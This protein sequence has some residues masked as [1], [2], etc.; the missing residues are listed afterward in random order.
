MRTK[1]VVEL[2]IKD[3]GAC[4][5]R[6]RSLDLTSRSS[7][8]LWRDYL[9]D[10]VREW[11]K[12]SQSE[13]DPFNQYVSIFTAYNTLYDLYGAM[14]HPGED[15]SRH[16]SQLAVEAAELISD[17]NSLIQ[18]LQPKLADY[19]RSIPVFREEYYKENNRVI[20]ISE[21]LRESLGSGHG[22][23]TLQLL[24]RWFYKVRCNLVHGGKDYKD[25]GQR[26][27][28][29]RSFPLLERIVDA[30]ILEFSRRAAIGFA[31]ETKHTTKSSPT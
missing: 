10:R 20:P 18:Q 12:K 3:M 27:L 13:T 24:L 11:Q 31:E 29:E 21:A 23:R 30:M 19:A 7:E 4:C 9:L 25:A 22:H 6:Q 1:L 8:Q 2:G 26:R 15:L 14:R 17:P 5:Y 28:L 16:D